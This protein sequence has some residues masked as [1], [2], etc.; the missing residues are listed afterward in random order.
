MGEKNF[1]I[2]YAKLTESEILTSLSIRSISHWGYDDPFTEACSTGLSITPAKIENGIVRV[3]LIK[4]R[5]LGYYEFNKINFP[6]VYEL[7]SMF[8]EPDEIGKGLGKRLWIDL[9]RQMV[10]R[11]ATMLVVRSEPHAA[12]FY[13]SMGMNQIGEYKS[14]SIKGRILP[15]LE[16]TFEIAK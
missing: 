11:A 15:I 10:E 8:V 7:Y 5:L 2:R 1:E 6:D 14:P 12:G 9:E 16:K 3:L 4:N 13:K